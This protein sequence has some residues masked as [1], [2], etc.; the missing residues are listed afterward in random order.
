MVIPLGKTEKSDGWYRIEYGQKYVD[1][2]AWTIYSAIYIYI[3][4]P[5]QR[6]DT[7]ESR[8]PYQGKPP[9]IHDMVGCPRSQNL[10]DSRGKFHENSPEP[11]L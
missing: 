11:W 1:F 10:C 3:Y 9:E 7:E 5:I 4:T 2:R 6:F 8:L